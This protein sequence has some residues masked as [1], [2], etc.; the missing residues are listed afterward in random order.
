MGSCVSKPTVDDTSL[1]TRDV[2]PQESSSI[3]QQIDAK[4]GRGSA[5]VIDEPSY[6]RRP[7]R[8]RAQSTPHKV[9]PMNGVELPPLPQRT[10]AKSTVTS[11]SSNSRGPNLDQRRTSGEHLRTTPRRTVKDCPTALARRPL[12]SKVREVITEDFRFRLLVV[13]ER[14][15]GKSS[16]FKAV[17][18][19]D[20]TDELKGMHGKADI[21]VEFRPEDNRY[22]VVHECSGFGSQL[23]DSQNLRTIREFVSYRTGLSCPPSERLHAVWICIPASDAIT[24]RFGEGVEEIL[25]MKNV[26]VILVLTKFD[27]VVSKLLFDI[28]LGDARQHENARTGA[29]AM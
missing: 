29:H 1:D 25:G 15:C 27:V 22:L 23:G 16:L 18:K 8:D 5:Q 11:S 9:P 3:Q 20:V 17:F 21:N 4:P 10:R 2:T 28:Y 26:P 12:D 7:T 19:V 13:G 6:G 14:Q 24:G